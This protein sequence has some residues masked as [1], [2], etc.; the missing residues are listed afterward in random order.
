MNKPIRGSVQ[1]TSL[2]SQ[3]LSQKQPIRG[4]LST[5]P[6]VF[7]VQQQPASIM[8]IEMDPAEFLS[9][10]D[11]LS[12]TA[13]QIDIPQPHSFLSNVAFDQAMASSFQSMESMTTAPTVDTA[14]MTRSSTNMSNMPVGGSEMLRIRSRQSIQSLPQEDGVQAFMV[15]G[16]RHSDASLLGY[17]TLPA[18]SPISQRPPTTQ[19]SQSV[20]AATA[21]VPAATAP[22]SQD[23]ISVAMKRSISAQSARSSSSIQNSL[24]R[25]NSNAARQRVIQPRLNQPDGTTRRDSNGTQPAAG[26]HSS[27]SPR[28]RAAIARVRP[29][30]PNRQRAVCSVCPDRPTFRGEHELRRHIQVRHSA[31]L[32]KWMCIKPPADEMHLRANPAIPLE[33][34]K[35]CSAK[36]QYNKDYNAAAHLRRKHFNVRQ[37]RRARGQAAYQP[38]EKRGGR[39][40]GDQPPMSELRHWMKKVIVY[41]DQEAAELARVDEDG[42]GDEESELFAGDWDSQPGADGRAPALVAGE[43]T[44]ALPAAAPPAVGAGGNSAQLDQSAVFGVGDV[45]SSQDWNPLAIDTNTGLYDLERELGNAATAGLSIGQDISAANSQNDVLPSPVSPM[46]GLAM[47][48]AS[49]PVTLAGFDAQPQCQPRLSLATP[50]LTMSLSGASSPSSAQPANGM[51][52]QNPFMTTSATTTAGTMGI[53]RAQVQ[54]TSS[55]TDAFATTQGAA[56]MLPVMGSTNQQLGTLQG[57]LGDMD[58]ELTFGDLNGN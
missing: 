40:G 21:F 42:D 16:K 56:A 38:E 28:P 33:K 2:L 23:P 15:P 31:R 17:P 34:C 1:A 39:G 3:S 6:V 26:A 11:L 5:A 25:Q 55:F 49:S 48:F 14:P 13:S 50:A 29:E 52:Q 32:E 7:P 20:P 4:V 10:A 35:Q 24:A 41:L 47:S 43:D 8:G 44:L 46:N 54:G 18:A 58:F 22:S 12:S 30:R 53:A 51:S 37:G 19:L 9:R 27:S 36:K 57:D 45:F